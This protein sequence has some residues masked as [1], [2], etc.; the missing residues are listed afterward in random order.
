ML[1]SRES[2]KCENDEKNIPVEIFDFSNYITHKTGMEDPFPDQAEDSPGKKQRD[3]KAE[4]KRK[5]E[6]DFAKLKA[7]VTIP[8]L[9]PP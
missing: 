3:E 5:E 4:Q 8:Y 2:I 7:L 6:E 1:I 9:P